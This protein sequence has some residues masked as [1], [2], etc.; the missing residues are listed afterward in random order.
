MEVCDYTD[1]V[2]LRDRHSF[3]WELFRHGDDV[4]GRREFPR[5]EDILK[6]VVAKVQGAR[7][8]P[9]GRV[10]EEFVQVLPVALFYQREIKFVEACILHFGNNQIE[11]NLNLN[12]TVI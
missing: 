1:Q 7:G 3:S 9:L 10:L 6:N 12:T 5:G 11:L 4:D 8:L 2:I